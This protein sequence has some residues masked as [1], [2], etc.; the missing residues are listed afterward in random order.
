MEG[1]CLKDTV[2]IVNELLVGLFNE[3]LTVEKAALQQSAFKD[4]SLTE[5]HVIEAIGVG[6]R[7]MTDVA[8]Q[9]GVTV[10]TLTTSINRLVKKEYVTRNRSEDDRR[11]VQIELT[12]KGKLAYRIH[13]SFHGKMVNYMIEELSNEDHEVL[14]ASLTRLGEFFEEKY[15][16]TKNQP[17]E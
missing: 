12:H 16:L 4:L 17:K 10:G 9:I 7:T 15:H 13:E 14:I 3:I 8:D 5:M 6:S 11:F 1:I 2:K